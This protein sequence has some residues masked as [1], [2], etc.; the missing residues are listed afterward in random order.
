MDTDIMTEPGGESQQAGTES[1]IQV[2]LWILGMKVPEGAKLL[3]GHILSLSRQTGY[4]WKSN[5]RY[6]ETFAVTAWTVRGWIKALEEAGLV[7]VEGRETGRRIFP[8]FT[9]NGPIPGGLEK[10]NPPLRES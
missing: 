5:G 3:A 8:L 6:A 10:S 4:A 2:P 7:R 1:F 9:H